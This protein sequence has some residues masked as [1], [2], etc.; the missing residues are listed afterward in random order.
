MAATGERNW[1]AQLVISCDHA[2]LRPHF[3]ALENEM[4][5][6]L[7]RIDDPRRVIAYLDV[8]ML[9]SKAWSEAFGALE[10]RK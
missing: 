2:G 4:Y 6:V 8:L 1:T 7:A 3:K 10:P 5:R 9:R